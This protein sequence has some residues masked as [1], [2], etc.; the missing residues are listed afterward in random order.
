M[1]DAERI[2]IHWAGY[3]MLPAIMALIRTALAAEPE[4]QR[5]ALISGV[6][7][8]ARSIDHIMEELAQ[9]RER[10]AIVRRLYWTGDHHI[11]QHA[12]RA[13]IGDNAL[14]NPRATSPFV[15]RVVRA[16]ERRLKCPEN[17]GVPIYHGC[18]WWALTRE[19]IDFTLETVRREPRRLTW[20]RWRFA[21]EEMFFPSIVA[22]MKYGVNPPLDEKGIGIKGDDLTPIHYI[23]WINPNPDL[24]RTLD[25]DDLPAIVATE[26]LFVRKT[27]PV[28]SATL[29]DALDAHARADSRAPEPAL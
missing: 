12:S 21:P 8:P 7:Y 2:S 13:W 3:S 11:D 19:A 29:L 10:V 26:A 9:D 17:Y 28:R 25:L 20:F 5:F 27:D 23:D 4:L 24:P 22:E 16:I 1:P 6:D 15:A 18:G 14:L